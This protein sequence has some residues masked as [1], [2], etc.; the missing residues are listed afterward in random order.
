MNKYRKTK[1][2][3]EET[4]ISKKE[5]ADLLRRTGW[6]YHAAKETWAAEKFASIDFPK[7][8]EEIA[9]TVSAALKTLTETIKTVTEMMPGL[10]ESISQG[11]EAVKERAEAEKIKS[12]IRSYFPDA[13][14]EENK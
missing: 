13:S 2:L 1:K 5:A 7:I 11:A 8:C 3:M 9:D 6:D 10:I 12:R 4:G 14:E